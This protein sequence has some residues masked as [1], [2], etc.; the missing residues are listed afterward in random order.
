MNSTL[1][2]RKFARQSVLEEIL[3]KMVLENFTTEDAK[4][5]IKSLRA[6]Y[7]Q[8]SHKIEKSL[9]SGAG[10][11]D[12]YKPSMKWFTLMIKVMKS[13]VLKRG[14]LSTSA[15]CTSSNLDT[16]LTI[17]HFFLY[18]LLLTHLKQCPPLE[19]KLANVCERYLLRYLLS[20]TCSKLLVHLPCLSTGL[21]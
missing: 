4:Q 10:L 17:L 1:Y 19:A 14:T 21:V 15:I 20:F 13:V 16:F 6:T 2:K 12:V 11:E 5:K 3:K 7:Q 18:I 9:G 8:E